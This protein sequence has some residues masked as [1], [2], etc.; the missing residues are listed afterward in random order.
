MQEKG[1]DKIAVADYKWKYILY[2]AI[3]WGLV[4]AGFL[5]FSAKERHWQFWMAEVVMLS[6]A[7]G[8]SYMLLSGKYDFIGRKGQKFDAYL[9]SKYKDILNEKGRFDY[10]DDGFIFHA[11][12]KEIEVKWSEIDRVTAHLEDL[13]SNDEDLCIKIEYDYKHFLEFDEEIPGWLLFKEKLAA[14]IQL[15]ENWEKR[16]LAADQK[17]IL[18]FKK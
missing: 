16:L 12:G 14:N 3:C 5:A 13:V 18:L 2:A 7:G 17:E 8:V 4:L 15:A 11:E 10:S 1:R 9:D 6:L